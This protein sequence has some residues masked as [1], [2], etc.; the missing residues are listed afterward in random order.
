MSIK[1]ALRIDPDGTVADVMIDGLDSMQAAVGGLIEP[2]SLHDGT[3]YV[4]DEGLLLGMAP[5][6]IASKLYGGLIVGSALLMGNGDA[7]GNDT[8]I[9]KGLRERA[10]EMHDV[11]LTMVPQ[12]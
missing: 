8:H 2:V 6:F 12:V 7:H 11:Y 1:R 3:M 5:N 9:T 10:L 4:N